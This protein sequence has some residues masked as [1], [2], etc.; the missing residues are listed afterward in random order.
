MRLIVAEQAWEDYQY[1]L[2]TDR[3]IT[4]RVHELIK[5]TM[6]SPFAGIGKPEPL[7]HA[8][9]GYWSRRIT[10]EHRL[11][12]KVEGN[13]LLLAQLRYHYAS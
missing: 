2:Q 13:S 12:Y 6:R 9:A 4:R 1:W 8:L 7:R 3:K 10:D 11:V 5:D